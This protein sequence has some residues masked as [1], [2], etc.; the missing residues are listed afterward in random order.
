MT[1]SQIGPAFWLPTPEGWPVLCGGDMTNFL[2]TEAEQNRI[3]A[4]L[5]TA[6]EAE[7][8]P[9]PQGLDPEAFSPG[10]RRLFVRNVQA[11]RKAQDALADLSQEMQQAIWAADPDSDRD[12]LQGSTWAD[13]ARVLG[14]LSWEWEPWLVS[15]ML[16]MVAAQSEMGKSI[17]CLRI[18]ACYLRGDPWPDGTPFRGERGKVLW[19]EAEAGQAI[20]MDRA[21]KWGLPLDKILTPFR[22]PLTDAILENDEH[23]T[24][25]TAFAL[26][27]DVKLI[28]VDSL[29]GANEKR[30]ENGMEML[31]VV[32]WLADL[33]K[34]AG[35]P[36][37]LTHHLRKRG[38]LDSDTVTLD[39]VRG[40]S[41]IVQTPRVVWAL[42]R[43]DPHGTDGIRLSVIKSNIA[44][45]PD[46]LGMWIDEAGPHFEND[47]PKPP[48]T[49][50]Q[51]DK[52]ADWLLEILKPG[53]KPYTEIEKE[54]KGLGISEVTA[55]RVK[56]KLGILSVRP[57]GEKYWCWALPAKES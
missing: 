32:K 50:T 37:L 47:A 46:P 8:G 35:K 29:S 33:A 28:V 6:T 17:L 48:R 52:A 44:K 25:I 20:N 27:P 26:Q 2:L 21:Q 22:D 53:P 23:R 54:L 13:L 34:V 1:G 51:E 30:D 40:S 4:E 45:K 39:R 38:I 18:A 10:E 3:I 49:E 14:P 57:Q 7:P 19:C 12:P 43:P 24:R 55:R 41:S 36:I 16:T 42:D 56:A 11:G 5:V 15:N 9:D 31:Q